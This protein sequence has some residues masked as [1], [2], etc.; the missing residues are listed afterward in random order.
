MN[1]KN[2][3]TLS[4]KKFQIVRLNRLEDMGSSP[5]LNR[6]RGFVWEKD[7]LFFQA[8]IRGYGGNLFTNKYTGSTVNFTQKNSAHSNKSL[9]RYGPRCRFFTNLNCKFP[10]RV[11]E[12][13]WKNMFHNFFP[14][15]IDCCDQS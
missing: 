10:A 2:E 8:L 3:I 4:P 9:A 12:V 11:I 5:F 7:R 14:A 13:V 6:V 1:T 15:L